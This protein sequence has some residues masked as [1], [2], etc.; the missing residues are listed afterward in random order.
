MRFTIKMKLG[1]AFVLIVAMSI[2]M[3]ALA[4][5]NLSS[6]DANINEM[7]HG[8]I[9]R[10]QLS[11][12]LNQSLQTLVE[13][14]KDGVI[15]TDAALINTYASLLLQDRQRVLDDE[16]KLDAVAT[17]PTKAKLGDFMDEWRRW[18]PIQD[19]IRQLS[20]T[21]TNASNAQ[22]GD[23]SRTKSKDSIAVMQKALAG[24][25]EFTSDALKSGESETTNQYNSAR[26]ILLTVSGLI[27]LVSTAAAVWISITVAKGLAKIG[28]MAKAVAIG[29]LNYEAAATGNDEIKDVIEA[30]DIM[31]ANLR[32]T[33]ELADRIA[34]GDLTVKPRPLS[35]KDILGQAL[36]RMVGRLG[37]VVTNAL[38]ASDNV[39]SGSQELSATSEQVSQGATEQASAAE[40]ASASMEE[41]AA[42]IKQNAEN[43]AT[44]SPSCRKSPARPTFWL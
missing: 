33:A 10:I 5:V 9:Y 34:D 41:M 35:D 21:N 23:L 29:D 3:A 30:V 14:E 13:T 43:A 28:A 26:N 11:A 40:Q 22:A 7:I 4:I 2:A 18:M 6:L 12:Q 36:E 8:P 24:I 17:P 38:I 42:N 32:N 27:L 15:N 44:R 37:D 25:N 31:T 1:M 39:S 19:Q 16:A 20:I